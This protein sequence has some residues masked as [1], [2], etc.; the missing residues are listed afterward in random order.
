MV[1]KTHTLVLNPSAFKHQNQ[2]EE[3]PSITLVELAALWLAQKIQEEQIFPFQQ[4]TYPKRYKG[5][6][7]DIQ[8]FFRRFYSIRRRTAMIVDMQF[9]DSNFDDFGSSF[10]NAA[11]LL[12]SCQLPLT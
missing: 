11:L 7:E 3:T 12:F 6:E 5:I 4:K 10:N 9:P 8:H 2:A 1:H